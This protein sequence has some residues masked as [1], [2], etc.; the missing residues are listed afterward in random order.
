VAAKEY[1]TQSRGGKG[2][3]GQGLRGEDEVM[4]LFPARS[5]DTVLFFSDKGKVYS[6]RVY[7][8]D[9]GRADKGI[10]LTN[11][12]A[13][14]SGERV[15]AALP[16]P[17]FDDSTFCVLVT[18]NGRI[19]RVEMS[20]F[21]SV[22]PS[23][24]IATNLESGDVLGWAQVTDGKRDIILVTERGQALRFDENE[25]RAMGRQAAGV[26]AIRLDEGDH[27]TSMDIV[28]DEC[29]VLV[30]TEKAYGKRTP[31]DEYPTYGRGSRGVATIDRKRVEGEGGT[32]RIVAARVVHGDDELTV[33]STSGQALRLKVKDIRQAGRST[34][35]NRLINLREGD[36]IASVARLAAKDIAAKLGE[37]ESPKPAEAEV[38]EAA[39]GSG[40]E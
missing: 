21:A 8:I 14:D 9:A 11:I 15:T 19:K 27:V 34:M 17:R 29:H 3:T 12:L 37:S 36:L 4:F 20:E 28:V 26:N 40:P 22:R 10:P 7:Q 39:N 31:V 33:I 35:G 5:L 13:I 2:V 16:V 18:R 32:G 24:L 30:V 38:T 23:G 6:E 1:R 25:V